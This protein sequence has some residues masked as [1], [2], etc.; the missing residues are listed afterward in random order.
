M[1]ERRML[2]HDSTAEEMEAYSV[3]VQVVPPLPMADEA[4]L[5]AASVVGASVVEGAVVVVLFM[6]VLKVAGELA[7]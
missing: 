1:S 2:V 6:V 5:V 4:V 7:I 3:T